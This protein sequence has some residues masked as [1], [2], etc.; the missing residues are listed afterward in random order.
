MC[1]RSL[2]FAQLPAEKR[3]VRAIVALALLGLCRIA[4]L[5][6]HV[7]GERHPRLDDQYAALRAA[8]PSIGEAGYLS[9]AP[10]SRD[11]EAPGNKLYEQAQY[12]LAPLI[13]HSGDDRAA[14]VI[15]VVADP[16]ALEPLAAAHGLRV[17]KRPAP[18]FAVLDK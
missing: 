13:L 9:D 16:A 12:A 14:L 5:H 10:P 8:M 17:V 11:P 2:D 7:E 4:W 18:N 15:A 6:F 3:V 1:S